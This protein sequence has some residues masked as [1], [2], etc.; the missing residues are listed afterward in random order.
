MNIENPPKVSGVCCLV[1]TCLIISFS[2]PQ[3]SPMVAHTE[4]HTQNWAPACVLPGLLS[5]LLWIV[6]VS[7]IRDKIMKMKD[8]H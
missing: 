1:Q 2:C 5:G 3:M 8:I 7:L 4:G 6:S